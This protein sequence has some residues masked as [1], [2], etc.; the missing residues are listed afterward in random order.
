MGPVPHQQKEKLLSSSEGLR[1]KNVALC[2]ENQSDQD[3]QD[4]QE[5]HTDR[6]THLHTYAV[7]KSAERYSLTHTEHLAVL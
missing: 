3:T 1:I 5:T 7:N 6:N 2:N 4:T